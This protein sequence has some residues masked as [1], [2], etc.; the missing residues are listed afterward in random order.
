MPTLKEMLSM[1]PDNPRETN[2]VKQ[3]AKN[4]PVTRLQGFNKEE[5]KKTLPTFTPQPRDFVDLRALDQTV[6]QP[7]DQN[8][9]SSW[10][11]YKQANPDQPQLLQKVGYTLD[12]PYRIPAVNKFFKGVDDKLFGGG[13]YADKAGPNLY[14]PEGGNKVVNKIAEMAGNMVG[15]AGTTSGGG[16]NLLNATDDIGLLAGRKVAEKTANK[17]LPTLARGAVDGGLGNAYEATLTGKNGKEIASEGLSGA[18]GGAALF[19]AGKLI[20]E[21]APKGA[22][23]LSDNAVKTTVTESRL[24]PTK[25]TPDMTFRKSYPVNADIQTNKTPLQDELLSILQENGIDPNKYRNSLYAKNDLIRREGLLGLPAPRSMETPLNIL[26]KGEIPI[27]MGGYKDEILPV[28]RVKKQ[29]IQ[30][31]LPINQRDFKNVGDTKIK[32]I[33]QNH[34]ELKPHIQQE[35]DILKGELGNGIRGGGGVLRNEQGLIEGGFRQQRF[36]GEGIESIKDITGKSYEEIDKALDDLIIDGGRE[37][38]A[39]A[40]RIELII[41]DRLSNGYTEPYTGSDILP[42]IDYLNKKEFITDQ[43]LYKNTLESG[44][45]KQ[46][47]KVTPQLKPQVFNQS[48]EPPKVQPQFARESIKPII[49]PT[50]PANGLKPSLGATDRTQSMSR[51]VS[52]DESRLKLTLK[53]RWDTIYTRFVDTN[54]PLKKVDDKTYV[55]ATNSKNVGGTVDYILQ[56]ALVD[57]KGNKIGES[58]KDI[59]KDIPKDE[60]FTF[61]NY[62][63]QK[64]NIDRAR[65]GKPVYMDFTSDESARA[66]S[67]LDK[68]YPHY[69]ALND[70]IVKFLND[71]ES[72]WGNKSGLISDDLWQQLQDTYK[73]Y[74]PTQRA[75]SN[76]EQ[77]VSATNGR[78]FVNQTTPLNK[79]TGSDRD[80]NNPIENIMNLVN[81]TVRTARYNEVGQ[82]LLTVVKK[83][84][85]KF[86]DLVEILPDDIQINP[87]VNNVVSVL[88]EG[89]PVNLQIKDKNLLGALE[90]IHKAN[91][92]DIEK[93]FKKVTSGF[94]ALITTKNPVFA[95]RNI[96][97]DIPTYLINSKE[98]NLFKA[99]G[100]LG[101]AVKDI[102]TNSETYQQYKAL[103]GGGSNFFNSERPAKSYEELI[104]RKPITTKGGEVLGFKDINPVKKALKAVGEKVEKLNNI[105]EAAPRLAEF[106]NSL[107]KG[108]SIER[109]MFDAADVTTNFSRGG[110]ITKHADSFVPYLNASVQGLDKLF[111][112]VKEKPVQTIIKGTAVVTGP[113]L[114]LNY[115]NKDNENYKQLD[116]RT[117]DNYYLF[118]R[119]DGTFIKIPKSR[120]YGAILSS[121]V[122]RLIR[123]YNGEDNAF[124]GYGN[125]LATN[126]SPTNPIENNILSPIMNLKSNKDFAN[127]DI[128]PRAMI[129]DK[130]SKYLQYDER[131]TEVAKWFAAEAKKVN[132]DLSPKQID[133]IIKSYTGVVAQLGQPALTRSTMEGGNTIEKL[134]KP[135]TTQFVADPLYSNQ[136]MTDFY[137]NKENLRNTATDKNLLENI[138]SKSVTPEEKQYN[139]FNKIAIKVSDLNKQVRL[140]ELSGDKEKVKQLKIELLKLASEANNGLK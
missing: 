84:P 94:K 2:S 105:T 65:E 140:A 54:S 61:M 87:N 18:V 1:M 42:N 75:F 82:E 74:V 112:Q 103:G 93:V 89:K 57:R 79:A 118:P 50:N 107:G 4:L 138:P 63:L 26:P 125:T 53:D 91:V 135:V 29:R 124:K 68:Q 114:L 22:K 14:T 59:A 102:A 136:T 128:V 123:Q 41:D 88:V 5:F 70:R 45:R 27:E 90:A 139:S 11:K 106:K 98:D 109:A 20:G 13:L 108:S 38:N 111:R 86:K 129:E 134:L 6:P 34:P 126:F 77:G 73:N 46:S 43:P 120:E 83:D 127:R 21:Y 31:D 85:V 95:V 24:T 101:G 35:A 51:I 110:D 100:N 9:L 3:A 67:L 137:D 62:V 23:W 36:M 121:L 17:L 80:V 12:T 71:F 40:K 66:V 132:L 119:E 131:T 133:Y 44:T 25:I 116:N 16:V 78:G 19:G 7:V 81:R 39:L 130:R 113:T 97:R 48:I 99:I 64:H 33:Q 49:E 69:K 52:S 8:N 58:L 96:F 117:K 115:V 15:L 122:E 76:L 55:K 92:G 28:S 60:E 30:A 56:D 32:A 47:L 10:E 37:N 72:E 104:G